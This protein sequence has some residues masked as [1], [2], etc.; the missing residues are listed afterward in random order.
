M[1]TRTSSFLKAGD[2]SSRAS[3]VSMGTH[4]A[5]SSA[6]CVH[7]KRDAFECIEVCVCV[8]VCEGGVKV[9]RC[10]QMCARAL[11]GMHITREACGG[12]ASP[13]S[14][15]C[16]QSAI[17]TAMRAQVWEHPGTSEHM[18]A[19]THV[20]WS[21]SHAPKGTESRASRTSQCTASLLHF[22]SG[23]PS[24]QPLPCKERIG[25]SGHLCQRA[26]AWPDPVTEKDIPLETEAVH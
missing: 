10:T 13:V 21:H 14:R 3:A 11:P 16:S 7:T 15:V 5:I 20:A 17:R 1:W 19:L 4:P 8:C 24:A 26:K 2:S 9:C 23:G 6:A 18:A 25:F 22:C 12:P